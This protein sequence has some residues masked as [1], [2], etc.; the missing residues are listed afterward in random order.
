MSYFFF[1]HPIE[2]RDGIPGRHRF[3]VRADL[4]SLGQHLGRHVVNVG[5][6]SFNENEPGRNVDPCPFAHPYAVAHTFCGIDR[7][8]GRYLVPGM[9][10]LLSE[11]V[12][13]GDTV[14]Y[15]HLHTRVCKPIALWVDTVMVVSSIV[16]LPLGPQM[17]GQRK[18]P[19]ALDH[20]YAQAVLDDPGASMADLV[21]TGLWTFNLQDAQA[22]RAHGYSRL[23]P[24]RVMLA[25]S[26]V[27]SPE[28]LRSRKAS[29]VPL[30]E[31]G[32]MSLTKL[33]EVREPN[34]WRMLE[35][36][37]VT[38][39]RLCGSMKPPV[40][41]PLPLGEAIY[42][43]SIRQSGYGGLHTGC[44]AIPPLEWPV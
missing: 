8:A 1:H 25:D 38:V 42:D 12:V 31:A 20:T 30:L 34:L 19:H 36:L 28:D 41:L 26:R 23:N 13:P 4:V 32:R 14:I 40:Q 17:P 29:F 5:V 35:A 27:P 15:G 2:S 44:V 24:H 3:A 43:A 11:A 16:S 9:G 21:T 39:P 22:G 37:V 10:L 33:T 6:D 7:R 18:W